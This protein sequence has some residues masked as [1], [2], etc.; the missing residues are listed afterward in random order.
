MAK[1]LIR[2]VEDPV[3]RDIMSFRD[4]FDRMLDN[5]LFAPFRRIGRWTDGWT[6]DMPAIDIVDD[7]K[8]YVLKAALPGWKPEDVEI[9]YDR[10]IVT[11]KGESKREEATDDKRYVRREISYK[12][13]S[14]TLT[15]PVDVVVEKSNAAFKDGVLTV[16]LP[17]TEIVKP[18]QIKVTTS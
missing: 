9:L 3:E 14:R 17:K 7:E 2:K 11:L 18:K 6:E 16:T 12:T 15:L 10:G 1:E 13:F 8:Q 4:S 5:G